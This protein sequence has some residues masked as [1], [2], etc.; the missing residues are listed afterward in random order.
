MITEIAPAPERVASEPAR[1]SKK[2]RSWDE[3]PRWHIYVPLS[4][5]LLFTLIP[6]YWILLFALRPAGST[7]LVPW[8]M[9]FDHFGKVWNER[10]SNLRRALLI[11]K[12]RASRRK[13]WAS[14]RYRL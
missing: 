7:S 12:S 9:T 6:F 5:Y 13:S 2:R 3:V 8:P 11:T 14:V 4:I 1:P 10:A